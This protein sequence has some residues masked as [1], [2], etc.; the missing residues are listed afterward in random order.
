MARPAK[1]ACGVKNRVCPSLPRRALPCVA[2][3]TCQNSVSP[4]ASRAMPCRGIVVDSSLWVR[5][6]G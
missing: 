1:P 2:C 5:S 3:T 6:G 4:S